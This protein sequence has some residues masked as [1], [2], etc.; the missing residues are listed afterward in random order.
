MLRTTLKACLLLAVAVEF[1]MSTVQAQN[2]FWA[3]LFSDQSDCVQFVASGQAM[4]MGRNSRVVPGGSPIAGPDARLLDP[5]NAA[6]SHEPGYRF[7]IGVQSPEH[8]IEAVFSQYGDWQWARSGSLTAGL[9]FDGAAGTSWPAGANT[10]AVGS[11]FEP[12]RIASTAG[13]GGE[14][15]E[16]DGL[17]PNAGFNDPLPTYQVYYN[18]SLQDLQ[19]N[20]ISNDPCAEVRIGFGYRNLQLNENAGVLIRGSYRATD[21]GAAN[22]GLSHAA[23]TGPGG[24]TFMGGA[25]NGFGDEAAPGNGGL[26]DQLTLSHQALTSNDLNGFQ[27]IVDACLLDLPRFNITTYVKAGAYHNHARGRVRE[28]YTGTGG[29]FSQYGRDFEDSKDVVS[30]VGGV[31]VKAGIPLSN[32]LQFTGGYEGNFISG[33]ALSPEQA[34]GIH[35]NRYQ[36]A[37]DGQLVVHGATFGLELTY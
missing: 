9:S 7:L 12:L 30:F 17:G 19:V 37:T 33:V 24:L 14:G 2:G 5:D 8:R 1:G 6:F 35:G 25:A 29:D 23:L 15:D 20:M 28:R 34:S 11:L 22:N 32:H 10:L 36:V 27:M 4:Y 26:P 13:L 18:S 31:A 16:D 21:I 3:D